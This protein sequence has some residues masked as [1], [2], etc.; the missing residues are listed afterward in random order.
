MNSIH[1]VDIL[2]TKEIPSLGTIHIRPLDLDKDLSTIHSWV[3]RPYAQYWG[4]LDSAPEKV[5]STYEEI[6]RS[7]T[8]AFIG[9]ISGRQ[10]FLVEQYDAAHELSA[11]YESKAGDTGMHILISPPDRP[12]RGF[13]WSIFST[14]MEF[15]FSNAQIQRVIVEPDIRNEKIHVLNKKAGFIYHKQISLSHKTA[16]LATCERAQ[17]HKA[18]EG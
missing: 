1:P 8:Q 15:L 6:L 14:V 4:L 9:E 11:Y 3:N 18:L 16:W 12:V 10:E 7:G 5:R 13:T 2:F 17:F